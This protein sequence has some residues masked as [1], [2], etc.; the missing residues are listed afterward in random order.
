LLYPLIASHRNIS[1]KMRERMGIRANLVRIA[2]G[3]ENIDD[4]KDDLDQA[5]RAVHA[6]SLMEPAVSQA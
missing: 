4:I 2:A 6:A 3:I 1:P 5:L